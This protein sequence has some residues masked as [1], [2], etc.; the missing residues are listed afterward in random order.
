MIAA[1]KGAG[2]RTRAREA[3]V[4]LPARR[5]AAEVLAASS[6]LS[7]QSEHLSTEVGRFLANVRAA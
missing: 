2:D 7:R 4:G 5:A 6:E 1:D 3:Q